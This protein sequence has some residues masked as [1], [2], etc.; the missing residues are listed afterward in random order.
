ML[1]KFSRTFVEEQYVLRSDHLP[2]FFH[3]ISF[4]VT[5]T[6]QTIISRF[7]FFCA[8][9]LQALSTCAS[10]RQLG[11]LKTVLNHAHRNSNSIYTFW[12]TFTNILD[13][14]NPILST[15]HFLRLYTNHILLGKDFSDHPGYT[16]SNSFYDS[17]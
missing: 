14:L 15:S 8:F 10:Y 2:S 4:M 1:L 12:I 5:P 3:G 6:F 16:L 17:S 9:F 7:F 11:Y 13:Y